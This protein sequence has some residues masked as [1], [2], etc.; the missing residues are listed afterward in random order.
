M[1][2]RREL[3]AAIPAISA[4]AQQARSSATFAFLSTD[5]AADIEAMAAEIIPT[6]DMPG[7]REA[8]V[9]WFIDGALAGYHRDMRPVIRQGLTDLRAKAGGKFTSLDA[10]RK[11]EL[12]K[13][14]ETTEFFTDVRTLTVMGF[15]ANPEYGGNRDHVGWKVIGFNHAHVHRAPF[16]AYDR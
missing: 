7:A 1:L 14:I 6:D 12:L 13:S 15:L 5:E 8:G 11:V 2:T 10:A 3:L 4:A 16:G 9:I